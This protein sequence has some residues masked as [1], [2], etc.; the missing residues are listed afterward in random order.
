MTPAEKCAALD[1]ICLLG[2][3]SNARLFASTDLPIGYRRNLVAYLDIESKPGDQTAS[4]NYSDERMA[5]WAHLARLHIIAKVYYR[6]DLL[7][8]S[9]SSSWNA[10]PQ[11]Q[12]MVLEELAKTGARAV[13]SQYAPT[14][15]GTGSWLEIGK[16]GYYLYWLRPPA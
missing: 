13:V 2:P 10:D 8:G 12:E 15:A 9:T 16:A 1:S 4:V 11:T 7:E 3:G 14:G 5:T 6:S